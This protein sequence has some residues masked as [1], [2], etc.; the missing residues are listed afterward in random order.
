MEEILNSEVRPLPNG[1]P[2]PFYETKWVG[3]DQTSWEPEANFYVNGKLCPAVQKFLDAQKEQVHD[4]PEMEVE[5]TEKTTTTKNTG[6][7]RVLRPR[8]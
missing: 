5:V 3:Y 2:S 8:I 4:R 6:S 7:A 1:K